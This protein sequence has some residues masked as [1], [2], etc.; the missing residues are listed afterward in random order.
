MDES[1]T[2]II[3]VAPAVRVSIG[4]E[5]GAEPG[6]STV[7]KLISA[8]RSLGASKVFDTG[9]AA[10]LTVLEETEEFLGRI[11][12]GEKLPQFTSCCPAWVKYA[13]QFYQVLTPSLHLSFASADDGFSGEEVLRQGKRQAAEDLYR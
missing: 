5:F 7:G 6:Q 8:L 2:V 10:D 4:E 13:E 1:K 12:K 9:F 11:Q 3:Q